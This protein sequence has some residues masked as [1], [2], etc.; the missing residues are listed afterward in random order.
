MLLLLD[1]LVIFLISDFYKKDLYPKVN[2]FS[3]SNEINS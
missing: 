3:K 2:K 1:N